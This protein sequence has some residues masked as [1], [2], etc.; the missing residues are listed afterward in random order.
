MTMLRGWTMSVGLVLAAT[1]A[2]AQ[3]APQAAGRPGYVA[4]SDFSGPYSETPP[5]A[6]QPG[7]G[8]RAIEPGY[9]PRGVEPG[10]GPRG[11]EPGYGPM[12]VGP[13]LLPP[14]E[15]YT[16]LRQNGFSP[17]GIPR[18]RGMFYNIAA[19]DRRGDDGRLVIDAR[20]GQIVRFV[21]AY[22]M[23]DRFEEGPPSR[24]GYGPSPY[25]YG[26]APMNYRGGVPRPPVGL[27]QEASR[28]TVPMPK[29]AP[30]RLA[31]KPLVE[32]PLAEK[33]APQPLQQSAAVQGKAAEAP[34]PQ[35]PPPVIEAKPAA[36]AILPTQ[37]MPKVQ[38]LE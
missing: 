8:P 12:G 24:Y 18:L 32:K 29:A 10:Y 14:R 21:P 37:P 22:R 7:Y 27:P 35:N 38:G 13:E 26:P 5:E 20:S 23:G 33:P 3:G 9:G 1:A 6:V 4:T 11:V 31:A 17:L 19:I 25:G 34:P 28:A 36:P 16:V 30:P 2:N 15:V